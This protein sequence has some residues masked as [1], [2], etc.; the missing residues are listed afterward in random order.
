MYKSEIITVTPDMAK[1]FL[2]SNYS[3]NR[4]VNR[5]IVRAYARDMANGN[6]NTDACPPISMTKDGTLLDGQHRLYAVIQ[7]NTAVKMEVRK[8]VEYES[9]LYFDSGKMRSVADMLHGKSK[10][11]ISTVG[12]VAYAIEHGHLNL[13]QSLKGQTHTGR[14]LKSEIVPYIE[15]HYDEL[16]KRFNTAYKL[17]SAVGGG[18]QTHYTN[19]L[20]IAEYLN[21]SVIELFIEDFGKDGSESKTIRRCKKNLRALLT[22]S[23]TKVRVEDV[24]EM[25]LHAYKLFEDG[26]ETDRFI[27]TAA[28]FLYYQDKIEEKRGGNG[29]DN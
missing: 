25:L 29:K 20:T 11:S 1:K 19:F 6:W 23:R 4:S 24:V 16:L 15:E 14:N 9:Y 27:N 3:G 8:G 17:K 22:N 5:N 7:A 13:K 2:A 10:A 26:V 28:T 21:F 18:A 12:A